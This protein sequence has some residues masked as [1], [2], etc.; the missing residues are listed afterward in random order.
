MGLFLNGSPQESFNRYQKN[1][2]MYPQQVLTHRMAIPVHLHDL[3]ILLPR[4]LLALAPPLSP[5]LV[6]RQRSL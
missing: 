4:L 5:R 6:I 3:Y 1:L 2:A